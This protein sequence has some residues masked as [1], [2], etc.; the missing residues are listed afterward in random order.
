MALVEDREKSIKAMR[1]YVKNNSKKFVICL[2]DDALGAMFIAHDFLDSM[3]NY[4]FH[5]PA[6]YPK[7]CFDTTGVTLEEMTEIAHL[8]YH[9]R[10]DELEN[11]LNLMEL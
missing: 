9:G 4:Y 1:D 6:L 3:R 2:A 7:I 10:W 5:K 8:N 11:F